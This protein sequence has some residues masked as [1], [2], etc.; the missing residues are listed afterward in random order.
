M[1]CFAICLAVFETASFLCGLD[2]RSPWSWWGAWVVGRVTKDFTASAPSTMKIIVVAPP[3]GNI[4]TVGCKCF[5]YAEVSFQP[6]FQRETP[7]QS[8][9]KCDARISKKLYAEF[10]VVKRH[11]GDSSIHEDDQ[12]GCCIGR[13]L[14]GLLYW[15]RT[16]SVDTRPSAAGVFVLTNVACVTTGPEA[17]LSS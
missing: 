15:R 9:I 7:F 5:R 2:F 17:S 11:D 3:D 16:G 1:A 4:F 10:R 13:R 8:N 14:G 6:S 12:G